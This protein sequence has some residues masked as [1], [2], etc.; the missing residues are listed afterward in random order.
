MPTKI[1]GKPQC[2]VGFSFGLRGEEP[3]LINEFLAENIGDFLETNNTLTSRLFLQWEIADSW[4]QGKSVVEKHVIRSHRQQG[5]YLDTYEVAVQAYQKMQ[6]YDLSRCIVAAHDDH[7]RRC[8]LIMEKLGAEVVGT[9]TTSLYDPF[10]TQWWTKSR[11]RFRFYDT[12]IAMPFFRL[13][14]YI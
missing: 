5:E 2:I 8:R 7:A 1:W 12:F 6:H 3:G 4:P 13:K 14:G 11:G 9:I 10:S